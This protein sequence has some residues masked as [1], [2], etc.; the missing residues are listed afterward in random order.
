MV[1]GKISNKPQNSGNTIKKQ[2]NKKTLSP[3]QPIRRPEHSHLGS[4]A[5]PVD[6]NSKGVVGNFDLVQ[7][8]VLINVRSGRN[9]QLYRNLITFCGRVPDLDR[10]G[11][12]THV[13]VEQA[14]RMDTLNLRKNTVTGREVAPPLAQR[15]K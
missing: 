10:G 6:L 5:L 4:C 3:P 9:R 13:Y 7:P 2:T 11:N 1:D 14:S 12:V 8:A 15:D